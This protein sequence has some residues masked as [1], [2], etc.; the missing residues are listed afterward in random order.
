[1]IYVYSRSRRSGS[2]RLPYPPGPK[3]APLIGNVLQIPLKGPWV[4]WAEW[5]AEYGDIFYLNTLG[6]SLVIL[7][8]YQTGLDL[9]LKRGAIYSDRPGL[10]AQR[11]IRSSGGWGFALTLD[12]YGENFHIKRRFINQTFNPTATRKSLGVMYTNIRLFLQ[13]LLR[14]P[15]KFHSYHKMYTA[16][17]IMM[18]TYGHLVEDENDEWTRNAEKALTTLD[19]LG[20][21]PIDIWP[22]L[23]IEVGKLPFAIWGKKFVKQMKEMKEATHTVSVVPYDIIKKRFFDGTAVPSMATELLEENL[24]ADGTI[25]HEELISGAC[26][27]TYIGGAD[28]TVASID[29]FVIAMILYPEIQ[30]AA[31]RTIDEVL[32]GER[33]PSF[34]DRDALPFVD[35]IMKEVL[36][37]RPVLAGG[38]PHRSIEDDEYQGMFIPKGST[39]AFNV[40]GMMYNPKDFPDPTKFSPQRFLKHTGESYALKTD[41]TDPEDIAFGFGRRICPGRHFATS[42]L[43]LA[44]ATILT[45]F[46]ISPEVDAAGNDMLPDLE[47]VPVVVSHP[48]PFQRQ[49]GKAGDLR[50]DLGVYE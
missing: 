37:W 21:H 46:D 24:R 48:K 30:S 22:S 16:A 35:A 11:L 44:I 19:T 41:E 34:E 50:H 3:G 25:A 29:T 13:S 23:K 18:V 14:E 43:W 38:I 26:A 33:L 28:T 32:Q 6:Q 5:A 8:S 4:K 10:Y 20:Q 27:I 17:N 7:N 42:W 1:M 2:R 40:L 39:V 45:V 49:S 9:L 12:T 31:R 15:T 47:Y 36:R